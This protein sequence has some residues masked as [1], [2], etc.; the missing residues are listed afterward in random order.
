MSSSYYNP[1]H[2]RR[3]I[4]KIFAA[5][6]LALGMIVLSILMLVESLTGGFSAEGT[7]ETLRVIVLILSLLTLLL[8]LVGA[9]QA[10]RDESF[11]ANARDILLFN[12]GLAVFSVLLKS[13]LPDFPLLDLID[14][15]A[16]LLTTL[17]V[18]KGIMRLALNMHHWSMHRLGQ[19]VFR[20][21]LIASCS[22]I[23]LSVLAGLVKS[24]TGVREL[25]IFFLCLAVLV[26]SFVATVLY[27]RYLHRA[28]EMTDIIVPE[29]PQEAAHRAIEN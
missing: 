10:A 6:I 5:N 25:L 22:S 1:V 15:A 28:V 26:L 24:N 7:V 2:A 17:F 20:L 21:V 14:D 29:Q 19:R 16:G 8:E 12:V 9:C 11:F 18:V 27:I 23:G 13:V 3:G 4:K